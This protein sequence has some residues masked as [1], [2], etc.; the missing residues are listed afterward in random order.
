MQPFLDLSPKTKG[1]GQKINKWDPIKL[2][3][4]CIAKE[5]VD[6]TERQ[7]IECEKVFAND[8]S[9]NELISPNY[10]EFL[11]LNVKQTT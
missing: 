3:N 5:T 9:N 8:I 7:P 2:K 4:F 11:Q 1:K 6:K 10:K